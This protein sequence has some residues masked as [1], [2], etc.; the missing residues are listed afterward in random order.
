MN[1]EKMLEQWS[2]WHPEKKLTQSQ[3]LT[4]SA[5]EIEAMLYRRGC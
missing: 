4:R 1:N 5:Y 2:N 3:M